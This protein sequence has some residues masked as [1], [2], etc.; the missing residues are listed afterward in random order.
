MIVLTKPNFPPY[1]CIQC[2]I[3]DERRKWYV[4]LQLHIDYY[5]N[6][7]NDGAIYL[8]NECWESFV[9]DISKAAQQIM[10]EQEPWAGG[11]FVQPTYED[12]SKI[13]VKSGTG[14]FSGVAFRFEQ[15]TK[16]DDRDTER[17]DQNPPD[18]SSSNEPEP[19]SD[20]SGVQSFFGGR[21]DG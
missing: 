15:D 16:I 9:V 7:V 13:E 8:C 14:S 17:D 1:V 5:L 3:G 6:P 18:D 21:T 4:D 20:D 2:G 11:E 19:S 12:E 10:F